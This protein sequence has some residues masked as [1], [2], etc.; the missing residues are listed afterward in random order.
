MAELDDP[1]QGTQ[2]DVETATGDDSALM[3]ELR[4]KG[5]SEDSIQELSRRV[6]QSDMTRMR[7]S[8]AATLAQLQATNASLTQSLQQSVQNVQGGEGPKSAMEAWMS[9]NINAETDPEV[10]KLFKGFASAVLSEANRGQQTSTQA[11]QR[12]MQLHQIDGALINE[13]ASLVERYG[14]KFVKKVWTQVAAYTKQEIVGG[15]QVMPETVI[16]QNFGDEALNARTNLRR[17]QQQKAKK[18]K[19]DQASGGFEPARRTRDTGG[20]TNETDTRD[21]MKRTKDTVQDAVAE[22]LAAIG[23]PG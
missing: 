13:R 2:L 21:N 6:P 14:E 5:V 9:E 4:A 11:L 10:A 12:Q 8:D 18:A 7:Q 20:K 15:R 22:G 17:T 23:A 19:E 3:E 16:L 1:E